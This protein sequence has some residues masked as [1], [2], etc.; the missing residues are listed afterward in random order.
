MRLRIAKTLKAKE[1]QVIWSLS[2]NVNIFS[3]GCLRVRVFHACV[4]IG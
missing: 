3:Q 4:V 2:L 1:N